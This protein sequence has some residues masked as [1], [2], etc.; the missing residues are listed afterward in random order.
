MKRHCGIEQDDENKTSDNSDYYAV[1][2]LA[3]PKSC[4]SCINLL[5][6]IQARPDVILKF[7][8]CDEWERHDYCLKFR[9][10]KEALNMNNDEVL[11]RVQESIDKIADGA[12]RENL[13]RAS[14][15]EVAQNSTLNNSTNDESLQYLEMAKG[16]VRGKGYITAIGYIDKA[17]ANLRT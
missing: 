1:P 3:T 2:P 15:D 16:A 8:L 12:V 9:F 4:R 17:I 11:Q 13:K 5:T 7:Q 10:E 6:C 14:E